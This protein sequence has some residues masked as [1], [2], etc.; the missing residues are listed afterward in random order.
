MASPKSTISSRAE[1]ASCGQGPTATMRF[2]VTTTAPFSMGGWETG[3]TMRARRIIGKESKAEGRK[4]KAEG[5]CDGG[6]GFRPSTRLESRFLA[7]AFVVRGL[8]VL[9]GFVLAVTF[10]DLLFHFFRDQVNGG[11]EV[12]LPVFGVKVGTGHGQAQGTLELAVGRLGGVV[13]QGDAGVDGK[14]VEVLQLP[15]AA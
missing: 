8:G 12:T 4:S 11:I 3:R 9:P 2:S 13:F 10:A 15:D 14:A 1:E 5:T 7:L 6:K